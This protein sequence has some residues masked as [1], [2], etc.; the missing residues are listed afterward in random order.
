MNFYALT[1]NLSAQQI[2]TYIDT[3][4][5]WYDDWCYALCKMAGMLD[6]WQS[7]DE[8]TFKSVVYRAAEKLGL[9]C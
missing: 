1:D 5:E 2:W 4:G 9:V 7:S 3:T 6:E 8:Y